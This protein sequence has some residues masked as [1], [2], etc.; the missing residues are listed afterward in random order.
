MYSLCRLT[1]RQSFFQHLPLF[2][3]VL[4]EHFFVCVDLARDQVGRPV[5]VVVQLL[6]EVQQTG[7]LVKFK[8]HQN[9]ENHTTNI[10]IG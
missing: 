5:T 9:P 3:A 10:E 8:V 2:A 6:A 4:F 7:V 1:Y